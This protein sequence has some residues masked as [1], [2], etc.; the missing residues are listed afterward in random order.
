MLVFLHVV[1]VYCVTRYEVLML[2]WCWAERLLRL[3]LTMSTNLEQRTLNTAACPLT[4]AS[5]LPTWK[6][7]H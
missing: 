3:L 2:T 4:L 5:S 6:C 1:H 7:Q